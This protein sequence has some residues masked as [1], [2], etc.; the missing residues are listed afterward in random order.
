MNHCLSSNER[1]RTSAAQ[2]LIASLAICVSPAEAFAQTYLANPSDAVGQGEGPPNCPPGTT[3]ALQTA[4]T[5]QV[6]GKTICIQ[7]VVLGNDRVHQAI[8]QQVEAM[9]SHEQR[10]KDL[11]AQNAMLQ[12]DIRILSSSLDELKERFGK[13]GQK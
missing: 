3:F 10:I 1:M 5:T 4:P 7:T 9:A 8:Q 2:A 13:L 11:I 12:N 6:G